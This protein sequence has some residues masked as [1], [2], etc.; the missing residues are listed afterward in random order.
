MT[1]KFPTTRQA[2][3]R[4]TRRPMSL[5]QNENKQTR[6]PDAATAPV[7]ACEQHHKHA[8]PCA[9]GLPCAPSRA[10]VGP[11]GA[12]SRAG[13]R[14]SG[15]ASGRP[16]GVG[17][18]F[19][20]VRLSLFLYAFEKIKGEEDESTS[21]LAA[22]GTSIPGRLALGS[23]LATPGKS[24]LPPSL[25][26]LPGV[27]Q[28]RPGAMEWPLAVTKPLRE[29]MPITAAFIDDLRDAFGADMINSAI[30]AGLDGQPTFWARENGREVGTRCPDAPARTVSMAD[31]NLGPINPANAPKPKGGR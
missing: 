22:L 15:R 23:A 24:S 3:R 4:A 9:R 18:A 28:G 30:R 2:T 6:R 20:R 10:R 21:H 16:S 25:P 11:S 26:N 29:A 17:S 1:P 8:F 19:S 5:T 13:L 14:P 7:C 31:I 27:L 12:R